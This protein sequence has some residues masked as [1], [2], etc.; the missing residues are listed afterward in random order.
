MKTYVKIVLGILAIL[1]IIIGYFYY[2]LF[3]NP[4]SPRDT[5][6]H[7]KDDLTIEVVYSR[8]YKKER[9]IFGSS[10]DGALV[11]FDTYWRLGANNATTFETSKE[12][13]FAGRKLAAGKYRMYAIP[14]ADHWT[15]VLNEEF[16]AFGY[17]KPDYDKDIMRVNLASAQLFTPVEQFTIDI[18]EER[19][20]LTLRMR[21]DT[22]AVSI[23]LN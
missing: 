19:E 8:P 7:A 1:A 11:P 23:P 17:I 4:V 15:I 3:I 10:E 2:I 9:L 14:F 6:T 13:S 22:T 5:V 16:S 18:L 12:I 20:N 21:W